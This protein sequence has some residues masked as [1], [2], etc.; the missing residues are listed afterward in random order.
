MPDA[1]DGLSRSLG[2]TVQ[3]LRRLGIGWTGR[4]WAFPM[5]G[6]D[7]TVCGIRIRALSGK[8]FSQRGGKDGL[9]VPSDLSGTGELVITEGPT[10]CCALL[11]LGFDAIGRPN[12]SGGVRL[13]ADF[14]RRGTWERHV[15]IADADG[16]GLQGALTL[17]RVLAP[18][19]AEVRIVVPPATDARAWKNTGATR[20]NVLALIDAA[21]PIRISIRRAVR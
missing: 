16:P 3:S 20:A 10:D 2:L 4:C 12:C 1:L 13:L 8:K 19:S 9:F 11:D 17:A 6:G 15:I 14:V 21:P 18:L 5:V 7:G